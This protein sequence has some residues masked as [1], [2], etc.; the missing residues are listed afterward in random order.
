MSETWPILLYRFTHQRIAY[1]LESKKHACRNRGAQYIRFAM[2]RVFRANYRDAN[3][4]AI[5]ITLVSAERVYWIPTFRHK[6][7]FTF[8]CV[9]NT[10]VAKSTGKNWSHCTLGIK[11]SSEISY[12]L[13]LSFRSSHSLCCATG[14]LFLAL[15]CL[16]F[17]SLRNPNHKTRKLQNSENI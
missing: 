15:L 6:Y 13:N 5:L 2:M 8:E 1:A 9:G 14:H 10:W 17:S 11:N 3:L 16:L 12:N 4:N 7:S